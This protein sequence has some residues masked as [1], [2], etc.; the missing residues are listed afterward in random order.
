M[1]SKQSLEV[2]FMVFGCSAYVNLEWKIC[3]EL[4]I[5]IGRKTI[6]GLFLLSK[7]NHHHLDL[8]NKLSDEK[9]SI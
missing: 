9:I 5:T 6:F 2:F 1:M 3:I 7:N 4:V 8:K